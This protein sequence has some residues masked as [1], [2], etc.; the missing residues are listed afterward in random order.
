[1]VVEALALNAASRS[2]LID[3]TST[4]SEFGEHSRT[5]AHM[6]LLPLH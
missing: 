5:L 1:M 4:S 6:T 3:G 2:R